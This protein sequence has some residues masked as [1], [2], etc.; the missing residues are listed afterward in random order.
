MQLHQTETPLGKTATFAEWVL[1]SV[2]YHLESKGAK[3]A[4]KKLDGM[5]TGFSWMDEWPATERAADEM[6]KNF[7]KEQRAETTGRTVPTTLSDDHIRQCLEKLMTLYHEDG[8]LLFNKKSH[9]QAVF[10]VLSDTGMFSLKDFEYFD[11]LMLRVMPAN[12]NCPYSRTS[13]K[14][15][16][17]TLFCKPRK[18]WI[19]EEGLMK[20]RK[21]FERMVEI[22]KQFDEL[23]KS[24]VNQ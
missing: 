19:Y 2:R 24:P 22:A 13:V 6:I 12:A 14:N 17:Q 7:G 4:Q 18:K 20:N 11:E 10:V 1:L 5:A 16:S 9:W 8:K 21:P 23:L 15:I 3:V